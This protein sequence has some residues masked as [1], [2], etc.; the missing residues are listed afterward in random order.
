MEVKNAIRSS[1]NDVSMKTLISFGMGSLGNNIICAMIATYLTIYLTDSFGI[2]AA[3][4]GTLFLVARI[5]DAITDPIMGV[6]VD[7]TK[8]KMGKSRPYLL[9]V[10]IFMG[11]TTIMCFSSPNLSESGKLI[12]I[13]ISYIL[14]GICF[15]AMD[16][17]YLSLSANITQSAQGRTKII[18]SARTIAFGGSLVVSVFTLPLVA[19]FGNWTT[20]A[21][22]Y[23][24][25]AAICTWIT[26]WGVRE[27]N[28]DRKPQKQGLKQL[29]E[30]FKTNKPLRI[31]LISM[32]MLEITYALRNGF[33]IYYIKYNF[34]AELYIPV[35]TGISIVSGMIGGI[36]TPNVTKKLGK[37][38]T[39]LIGIGI[40]AL[41]FLLIF[42]LKYSNLTLMLAINTMMGIAEGAANISLASMVADCVEYGEW[43][44]GK[45]SEGMI[46]SSNI[47]K[48]KLASAIGGA[49]CGYVLAFVGYKANAVQTIST[50]NGM[51][52]M[53]SLIPG[54]IAIFSIISLRRYNLTEKEYEAILEDLNNG[55]YLEEVN[56]N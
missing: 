29:K 14:W 33:S 54:I 53:Y 41:G 45:R 56:S 21:V 28:V 17:P 23:S 50:L 38:K 19:K 8:S 25:T 27:I 18:T 3:A 55:E 6:I 39:A 24:I 49:L 36:C 22:V 31:L 37:R 4:V 46:F 34:N 42:L 16:T 35:V 15:T 40:N 13:Y 5:I 9:V 26:V 32:L 52:V 7:N 2:G 47:F 11:I 48:T 51:H 10:P 30:L 1:E 43:K 20:V 44:T 12:W